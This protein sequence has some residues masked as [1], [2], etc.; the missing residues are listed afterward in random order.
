[1]SNDELF[2]KSPQPPLL[3]FFASGLVSWQQGEF[4][5]N[6]GLLMSNDELK[7]V[8]SVCLFL[9]TKEEFFGEFFELG[10]N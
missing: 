3:F 7:F 6:E 9:F 1:M 10:F 8:E 5:R 4:S 2:V